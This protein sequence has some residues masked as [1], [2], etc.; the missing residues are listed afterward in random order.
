MDVPVL[1]TQAHRVTVRARE[2]GHP[3]R[4][5]RGPAVCSRL[6]AREAA[7]LPGVV[8]RWASSGIAS[9]VVHI[10]PTGGYDPAIVIPHHHP[11]TCW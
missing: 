7:R 4:I 1:V 10:P 11:A 5:I 3:P 9:Q 6:Q 2:M 8:D